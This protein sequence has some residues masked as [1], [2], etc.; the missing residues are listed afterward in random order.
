MFPNTDTDTKVT[1]FRTSLDELDMYSLDD[2][3]NHGHTEGVNSPAIVL[4]KYLHEVNS[5]F[6]WY[7]KHQSI[8]DMARNSVLSGDPTYTEDD[9]KLASTL[10]LDAIVVDNGKDEPAVIANMR[11][12][13]AR[14]SAWGSGVR[15]Q[16]Q[17]GGGDRSCVVF[18]TTFEVMERSSAGLT[19]SDHDAMETRDDDEVAHWVAGWDEPVDYLSLWVIQTYGSFSNSPAVYPRDIAAPVLDGFQQAAW[20][21]PTWRAWERP[22]PGSSAY[23]DLGLSGDPD[24]S[25][26]IVSS[27]M[28]GR[29]FAPLLRRGLL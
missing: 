17:P 26:A 22:H 19:E 4:T 12:S 14:G 18:G 15:I 23:S 10:L 13:A 27:F 21:D 28:Q 3:I 20:G 16:V 5:K 7:N 6:R 8:V 25:P 24:T 2:F 9:S 1:Y 11:C 29:G